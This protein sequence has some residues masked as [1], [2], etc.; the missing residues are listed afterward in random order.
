[1]DIRDGGAGVREEKLVLPVVLR[2]GHFQDL[3]ARGEGWQTM[4]GEDAICLLD[5]L[6]PTQVEQVVRTSKAAHVARESYLGSITT[7]PERRF[8]GTLDMLA[9]EAVPLNFGFFGIGGNDPAIGDDRKRIQ[10]V[11]LLDAQ[12]V[13]EGEEAAHSGGQFQLLAEGLAEFFLEAIPKLFRDGL[14]ES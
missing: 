7:Q 4:S 12:P 13:D 3:L 11:P 2:R 5:C 6:I 1:V 14:K 9:F 10:R 8:M